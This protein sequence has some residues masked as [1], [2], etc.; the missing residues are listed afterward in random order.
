MRYLLLALSL[1]FCAAVPAQAQVS[2]GV[3]YPG[4]SIGI[5]LPAYPRLVP[6]PGYPVYY[7]PQVNGNYFFY[8]G[9]YWV[10]ENDAWYSSSWYNGP[11]QPVDPNYVPLYVLRVPV[12]YYHR[13]PAYFAYWRGDAAPHWGEHWGYGWA[14]RHTGWDHWDRRTAPAPAPL[15]HYQRGYSGDR[16]PHAVEQQRTLHTQNY[17]YQPNE[18]ISRQYYQHGHAGGFEGAPHPQAVRPAPQGQ[19]QGQ[20][21]GQGQEHKGPHQHDE[22]YREADRGRDHR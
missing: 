22:E 17:R 19:Y 2:F 8:D 7:D 18:A 21:Q 20:A 6:V 4:V 10:Y 3:G 1:A 11:W 15:P 5:N 12:R 14:S 16:Y 13:P 9:L